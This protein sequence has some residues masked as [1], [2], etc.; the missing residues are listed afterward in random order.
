[1]A[2]GG[3]LYND[4]VT[5]IECVAFIDRW[6][7]NNELERVGKQASHGLNVGVHSPLW[8]D[9][10]YNREGKRTVNYN[11]IFADLLYCR[12]GLVASTCNVNEPRLMLHTGRVRSCVHLYHCVSAIRAVEVPEFVCW[13]SNCDHMTEVEVC[14][15]CET[16]AE[17]CHAK[18]WGLCG[19]NPAIQG[20]HWV[21]KI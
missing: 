3:G 15:V 13:H 16:C 6:L 17:S 20:H 21:L 1:M 2:R 8:S 19:C 9:V 7:V 10:P 4:R 18:W 14:K 11:S 5:S 12:F